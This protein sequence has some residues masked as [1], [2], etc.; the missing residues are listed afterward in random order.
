LGTHSAGDVTRPLRTQLG[1]VERTVVALMSVHVLLSALTYLAAKR[2]V[3]EVPPLTLLL[4]RLLVSAG[5]FAVLLAFLPGPSLPPRS[6]LRRVLLLGLLSGPLNQ[7]LFLLAMQHT[8]A[9]HGALIF[10]LT[11]LGV[12]LVELARGREQARWTATAGIALALA[13]VLL[14]LLAHGLQALSGLFLGDILLLGSLL[15]WVFYTT[16]GRE[17]VAQE[18]PLRTSA[19][20]NIAGALLLL[21]LAPWVLRPELVFSASQL[22][23]A[24]VVYLGLGSSVLSYLIWFAALARTDASKVAVFSNLQPVATALAAWVLL[25]ERIGWEVVVGGALVLLGV[26]LTQ[27]PRGNG[28]PPGVP[29]P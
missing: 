27:A 15:A 8:T 6:V 16:E 4:W 17:L 12:Y 13:G 26:R 1:G 29:A 28:L 9:A 19:W 3:L 11:P 23:K 2:G 18:G 22:A 21:P 10:S 24:A 20:S 5:T 25:G 7:A 14:L